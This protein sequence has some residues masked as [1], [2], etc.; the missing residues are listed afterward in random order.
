MQKELSDLCNGSLL[1]YSSFLLHHSYTPLFH[2]SG[3]L[4]AAADGFVSLSNGNDGCD[5]E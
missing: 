5:R 1:Q 3:F 4:G 2:Y